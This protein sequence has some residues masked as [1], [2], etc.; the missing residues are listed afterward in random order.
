LKS[1][2]IR[3][4]FSSVALTLFLSAP[5]FAQRPAPKPRKPPKDR[6]F[7]A[8]NAGVQATSGTFSDNFTYQVN[9]EDATVQAQYHLK[10]SL[11]IDAAV[12]VHVWKKIVGIAFA[13]TRTSGSARAAI[14]AQVPH[15]FFD[16]QDREVSGDGTGLERAETAI[17][18]DGYY[19]KTSGKLRL[20]L[21]GGPTWFNV[22]QQLVTA[23]S[24]QETYPYDT[25]AFR[26]VTGKR[27]KA[28]AVGGNIGMD[29]SWMFSRSAGAGVL[30]RYATGQVRLNADDGHSV[31]TD[32]GGFQVGAGLRIKF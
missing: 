12:G 2:A 32:A 13:A 10:T 17:H 29:V 21:M 26:D 11:L 6:G 16:N 20:M 23:V 3:L 15:P 27:V 9:A 31:S 19:L 8:L 28:S 4:V 14:V 22:D 25:A 7:I 5:V 18:V 30:A 1:P 24:L